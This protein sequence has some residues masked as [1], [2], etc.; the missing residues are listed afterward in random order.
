MNRELKNK[1][2]FHGQRL[3]NSISIGGTA[4]PSME[5]KQEEA[6]CWVLGRQKGQRRKDLQ[7]ADHWEG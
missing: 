5:Q 7:Q 3:G 2:E 4:Q 1:G 6:G